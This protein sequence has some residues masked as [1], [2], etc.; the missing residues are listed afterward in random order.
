MAEQQVRRRR[1]ASTDEAAGPRRGG[2]AV[3]SAAG[4]ATDKVEDLA[5]GGGEDRA[6]DREEQ[7]G[8]QGSGGTF[9]HEIGS[10]VREAAIDVLGPVAKRATTEAAKYAVGKGPELAKSFGPKLGPK[11]KEVGPALE[12]AGGPGGLAKGALSSVKDAGGGLLSKVGIG[13]GGGGKPPSGTGRGRRL[14]VQESVDI[15]VPLETAYNQF[16]QFEDFGRFMFRT[17]KV[18]Q[19][20]DTHLVWHEK[21]WGIRRQVEAEITE[22]RPNERIAWTTNGGVESTGV[23]TFHELSDRLTRVMVTHD[24]QPHGVLEKT[25]SGFRMSRRAL[26][27]DLMRFKAFIEMREE[28]TGAWRERIEDG[29]VAGDEEQDTDREDRRESSER[30]RR[31]RGRRDDQPEAEEEDY[32]E[33]EDYAEYEEDEDEDETYE[34]EPQAQEEPEEEEPEEQEEPAEQPK[35]RQTRRRAPA[36]PTQSSRR[37]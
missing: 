19:R 37:R 22:Q 23:V 11:L 12:D 5:P 30:R 27:S 16:T 8:E 9:R 21:I 3:K 1:R 32:D 20:D 13:G 15:A 28:E 10:I 4:E 7:A 24:F 36:R 14:P 29:E 35:R 34:S 33:D 18:E 6:E 26:R 17:E 2:R 25:A 31:G